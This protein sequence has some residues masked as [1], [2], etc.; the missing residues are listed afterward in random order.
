MS[1][2]D[3]GQMMDA[4]EQLHIQPP[5]VEDQP[6]KFSRAMAIA[7]FPVPAAQSLTLASQ[8]RP[9]RKR[10][11][12]GFRRAACHIPSAIGQAHSASAYGIFGSSI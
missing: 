3:K 7:R 6:G 9:A 2:G 5:V 8:D 12:A 10:R 4:F 11:Q 1:A